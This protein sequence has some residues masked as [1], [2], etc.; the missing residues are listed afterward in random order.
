MNLFISKSICSQDIQHRISYTV[1]KNLKLV[2][3]NLLG[4][5]KKEEISFVFYNLE[6][7]TPQKLY[8]QDIFL[9]NIKLRGNAKNTYAFEPSKAFK[10]S[11]LLYALLKC[12]YPYQD[13]IFIPVSMQNSIRIIKHIKNS[14]SLDNFDNDF[15]NIYFVAITLKP[16]ESIPIYFSSIGASSLNDHCVIYRQ[17]K[18][19]YTKK[20]FIDSCDVFYGLKTFILLNEQNRHNYISL[21]ELCEQ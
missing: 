10:P 6:L 17:Q 8:N 14:N 12:P 11:P 1:N 16:N 19:D 3:P 13:D 15:S 2:I 7:I 21:S 5:E 9:P 20:D 4:G 18:F